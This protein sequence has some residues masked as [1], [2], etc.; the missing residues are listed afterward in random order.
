MHVQ[1]LLT[2]PGYKNVKGG[3]AAV[4]QLGTIKK[5][6]ISV[7]GSPQKSQPRGQERKKEEN[8]ELLKQKA[9]TPPLEIC[10]EKKK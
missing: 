5:K 7:E 10:L 1:K 6:K 4:L 9:Q 3:G 8:G 2:E